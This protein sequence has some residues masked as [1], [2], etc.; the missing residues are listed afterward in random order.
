MNRVAM[1]WLEK[2]RMKEIKISGGLQNRKLWLRY[3]TVVLMRLV[4]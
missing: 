1:V 3:V 2:V 4:S